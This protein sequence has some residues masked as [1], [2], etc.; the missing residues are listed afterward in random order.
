MLLTKA[1]V[2]IIKA[3]VMLTKASVTFKSGVPKL[4]PLS[5]GCAFGRFLSSDP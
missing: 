1:R 4:L 2:I 5:H 3:R